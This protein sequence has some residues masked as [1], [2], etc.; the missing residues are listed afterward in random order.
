VVC[1]S[2]DGRVL[3][4]HLQSGDCNPSISEYSYWDPETY[5]ACEKNKLG[6]K[7]NPSLLN[8]EQLSYLDLSLND[9]GGIQIP[10]FISSLRTLRYLN[11]SH[12]GFGGLIPPGLGNL[13]DLR[14]LDLGGSSYG[15]RRAENVRWLSDLFFLQHLDLSYADLSQA[16][17]WLQVT[18]MLPSLVDLRL[19]DCNLD[20]SVSLPNMVNFTR[21]AALDISYNWPFRSPLLINWLSTLAG[22]RFLNLG[23]CGISGPI[24][25]GLENMTRLTHVDLSDNSLNSSIPRWLYRFRGLNSLS[26]HRNYLRGSISDDI[27]NMTS[28]ISIDMSWNDLEGR[29]PRSIQNLC[30]L[31]AINLAENGLHDTSDVLQMFFG[32]GI[33]SLRELNLKGC[34][35]RGPLPKSLG[36][37]SSLKSLGLADNQF[38]GTLPESIGQLSK[39]T[40][41]TLFSNQFSGTLP[42]S[43]GQLSKLTSLTLSSNQFTG[44][45]PES[46]GQLS[47]FTSLT[48][49]SNQFSG[50][51]PESIGQ[52]SKLTSLT[53]SSNQFS[54]TLPES[55]GQLSK[56][57]SLTL[58]SNQFSGTLPQ[59]I[60]KLSKLEELW[61]DN[62]TLEGVVSEVHFANLS[63]LRV[64]CGDDNPLILQVGP[65]WSPPFQL[66]ELG[67]RSW[68]CGSKFP[69]WLQAQQR[70]TKLDLSAA[71]ISDIV[72]TWFWNLSSQLIYLNL[73]H[74]QLHGVIPSIPNV[75]LT[76]AMMHLSHNRFTGSLP[77]L[78]AN[79]VGLDLS[80][81]WFT[82]GL[83]HFLCGSTDKANQL[84]ILHLRD[85]L[86]SGDIPDCWRNW[87]SLVYVAL[88]NNNLKGNIPSSMGY[89]R[90]LRSLHLRNNSLNGEVPMALQKCTK[91]MIIDLSENEF[92]GSIT[93][94]MG[95]GLL[96]LISLDLRLNK[97]S[98]QIPS[99][100]CHLHSLQIL[101]LAN[102]NL[103]GE[104]PRC[105]RNFTAMATEM[106]NG[107]EIIYWFDIRDWRTNGLSPFEDAYVVTKGRELQYVATLFLVTSMDLS[108]NNLSGEIPKELTSLVRLRSLNL[109]GNR[110]TGM[111]P[112][113][114]GDMKFLESLDFSRNQLSGEIPSSISILTFLSCL[115]LSFNNL[116][117]QI[118]SGT[119]IQGFNAS[120]FIGNK[121]CGPPVSKN[122]TV[123]G[124]TPDN[125]N[126]ESKGDRPE[127]DWFYLCM[128]LGFVVG[129][130]VTNMLSSLV[131]I[132]LSSCNINLEVSRPSVVKFTLLTSLNLSYNIFPS[133]IPRV[134]C[135]SFNGHVIEL[136]LQNPYGVCNPF[137]DLFADRETYMACEKNKFRGKIN[138]SLLNLEQLSYLDLSLNDFGGIQI[139]SFIS[140]LRT[141]RYLNLSGAGF[142]GL[143][144]PGLGNLSDLRTLDLGGSLYGSLRAENFRWLSDLSFLQH[145]DLSYANLS[146][147]SDWLQVTNMLPSLVDLRLSDCNL[148]LSVSL[149]NIESTGDL[150]NG[151]LPESIGQLSK[152]KSLDLFGNHFY[153][154]L[155]E[156]IGQLS[157]L[158]VLQIDDNMLEGVVSEVHFANLSNLRVFYG[159]DN[160]LILQVNPKWSPPFQLETLSLR[161]WRRVSKFPNWLQAQQRLNHLDL[162]STR[163]SD[164]VPTWF[165]NLSSQ[166][167][168]LNLSHNQLHG[169]IPSIPKAKRSYLNNNRFSGSLPRLP[170]N[171]VELDLSNNWFTGGGLS[172]LLCGSTDKP[173][174][175]Q[176]LNLGDNLLSGDIPDCWM[177]WASL[178]V[179]AL[180]NNNFKGN[181]PS[182]MGYLSDLR[183]LHL[184]NN[185]LDGEV[186]ITLQNCT[187]L[188][189]IDLSQNEFCG[190]TTSWMGKGLLNLISLDLR[191]NKF[192]GQIPSDICHLNSLQIL[193]LADNNLSGEIPRCMGNFTAM[194]TEINNG[195]PISIWNDGYAIS[196]SFYGVSFESAYVVT[197]GRELQYDSTLALVK[198]MDL[199]SNSVS[200]EIPKELT[201]LVRLQSLNLSRNCLTGMIP[202]K[203]GDMESLESL[204]FSRNQL[205]GEI[206][207]TISS[208]TFLSY[209]NLSFNNFSGQIPTSTQLQ[210]FNASCFIGNKL[211]G[212]PVS[213]NCTVNGV[214]PDNPNE[215]GT[216]EG[217]LAITVDAAKRA[218][219]VQ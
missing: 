181:I 96:N 184:R 109:S 88:E 19:S 30:R 74:N 158:E 58:S 174:N 70:L 39:L 209:L 99:D 136:H 73:S 110:L 214:T 80:N 159:D 61:I 87:S 115:N 82:G 152:L 56:L 40:S 179:V 161:S 162:S 29:I 163:I 25:S 144:P 160:P 78:S 42:E 157:K 213:K 168:Y 76:Y 106:S 31:E 171:V 133:L 94:W 68:R 4:L 154:T 124:V 41:L 63:N 218:G 37:L 35:I 47:K 67:I 194:A 101:D 147:A 57:T 192:S 108:S 138:P 190:S 91:L 118:P 89:L 134:V 132:R 129:F 43:I 52:L 135:H 167:S 116:S 145:L 200:G 114:I 207:L 81:N 151:T 191:S 54:G 103:S 24:P 92:C 32:C 193:D 55:I 97:F 208:L 85:N 188:M 212:P 112:K 102:N 149:P 3:E 166:F 204:D 28:I 219:E 169:V 77:R 119:Q 104:I 187:E 175:L 9:F 60:G 26:L 22:L 111:I 93:S 11:L 205:S 155:P 125:R 18:N 123:N 211:C 120:C 8:L 53:L 113:K 83:S 33:H 126:E 148:D 90:D 217:F 198:S 21:L 216:V 38:N 117:G 107:D 6:G 140:S 16:S 142:G 172:H 146:Q 66:E 197:K 202:K 180:G 46:I 130:W 185:R 48:L 20:L 45:L 59:S 64:F 199:S 17:D 2:F 62:N 201:S 72:P 183:S 86:L 189:V 153:G 127:V 100:I 1:H 79:V 206:P 23:G 210:S 75:K 164:I 122:C 203:I 150:F 36:R 84:Q 173:N 165:C 12:A 182:S 49:S 50:T 195:G 10:S 44:T 13:S 176:I 128:A 139:P 15:F 65:K 141:L 105:I 95:K 215:E 196:Y 7:I 5:M 137:D 156:S 51:L 131:D 71:R 98:G 69:N 143:I 27:G 177:S 186:P 170:P 34:S 121:L 14:T 178:R